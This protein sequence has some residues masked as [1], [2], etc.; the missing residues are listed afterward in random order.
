MQQIP[1][2]WGD[3][4]GD[5]QVVSARYQKSANKSSAASK[6]GYRVE[7]S[8]K[9]ATGPSS[10]DQLGHR[11]QYSSRYDD[12]SDSETE[13]G[14]GYICRNNKRTERK[15]P[16][17]PKECYSR[18]GEGDG[19]K[20]H[21]RTSISTDTSTDRLVRRRK[22]GHLKPEKFDG[23]TCFETFLVRFDNCAQFNRW[24]ETEKLHY[25]RWS[26]K[27]SAA[28]MLWGADTRPN[29]RR[30]ATV[31]LTRDRH[32]RTRHV[33]SLNVGTCSGWL[34][35]RKQPTSLRS[36]STVFSTRSGSQ[37]L[38]RRTSLVESDADWLALNLCRLVFLD[39]S[40][41]LSTGVAEC[42]E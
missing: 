17:S 11:K 25:L 14:G 2:L 40:D 6:I 38:F 34:P 1:A 24:D 41:F 4:A 32:L 42:C 30:D 35:D 5:A 9:T 29:C 37:S 7:S 3:A 22:I 21:C 8:A 33:S 16:D 19:E 10:V 23:T 31:I 36:G 12:F 18:K 15:R 28:Q 20:S 27:G 39:D 13:S 26:L